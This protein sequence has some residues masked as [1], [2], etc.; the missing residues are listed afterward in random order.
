MTKR[1]RSSFW[2]S[3]FTR[4]ALAMTR[5]AGASG[6][7]LQNRA[8]KPAAARR[9]V[10][11]GEGVWLPG[12]AIGSGGALRFRLFLPP[13]V[14]ATEQ[15]PLMVMLHGCGQDANGFACST[16]M[17]HIAL[18]E[19]FLVLYPEQDKLANAQGCWNWFDTDSGRA[20]AEAEL[21]MRAIDQVC[22]SQPVDRQRVALAGLSAGASM[23][24]LLVTR[25]PER[26]KA[27]VMHSGIPPGTAHSALTALGAMHGRRA[28]LPLAATPATLQARWP[29]L[30][31][32]H[33]DAD[34]T[35]SPS[36]ARAAALTWAQAAGA[37]ASAARQV[38]RGNR[39]AMSVTDYK[40]QGGLVAT[41]VLVA[42]LGHAW[43]G[44]A[45]GQPYG[46]A[47][48]PDA[49]RMAWTFAARQFRGRLQAPTRG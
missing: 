46:D 6:R 24:A 42:G 21:I 47:R 3:S 10:K 14:T 18:R 44:G 15:L 19:R 16:G 5:L 2:A 32:V 9:T 36:N 26:F 34:R 48:G 7:R 22:S 13:G 37:Q 31:V 1:S 40:Q 25:H 23:G 27:L 35:V 43:S 38:Q 11:S 41:Q 28:T 4:S 49:S 20:Q 30:L 17:N 8:L 33:G 39:Y 45:A 29:A 12:V